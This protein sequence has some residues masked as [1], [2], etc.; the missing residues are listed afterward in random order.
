MALFSSKKSTTHYDTTNNYVDQSANA[1]EGA[2]SAAGGSQIYV[3]SLSDDVALGALASN[4]NVS[5]AALESN[6][7][8]LNT[9]GNLARDVSLQSIKTAEQ[10]ATF[11]GNTIAGMGEVASRERVDVLNTTNTALQS[12]QGA[13]NKLADLAAGA[14]E[15][16]QTPDSQVTKT[17]LYVVGAVALG[18]V[19]LLSRSRKK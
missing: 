17:L 3:E 2:I 18:A 16:S 10:L 7:A 11:T 9:A 19:L 12:S 1:A 13:V 6:V 14:L 5:T 8:A 4:Q 15:R